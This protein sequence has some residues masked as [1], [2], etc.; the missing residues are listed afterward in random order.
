MP[1]CRR[2]PGWEDGNVW[3]VGVG[4]NTLIE[5]GGEGMELGVPKGETWKAE[6]S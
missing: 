1:Q 6:N 3:G 5:S 4:G 2:M